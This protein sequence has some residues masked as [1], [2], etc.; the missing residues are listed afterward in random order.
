MNVLRLLL[1]LVL[2]QKGAEAVLHALQIPQ[3]FFLIQPGAQLYA[4]RYLFEKIPVHLTDRPP[5]VPDPPR[6]VLRRPEHGIFKDPLFPGPAVKKVFP[7]HE[8]FF[9]GLER[10]FLLC[11]RHFLL[12]IFLQ[13]PENRIH[14]LQEQLIFP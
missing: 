14:A 1:L 10:I 8:K 4:L 9:Y 11:R 13:I 3:H 12:H 6:Q 7:E 2:I 5:Q